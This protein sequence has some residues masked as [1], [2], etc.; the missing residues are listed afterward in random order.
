MTGPTSGLTDDQLRRGLHH[1]GL[2]HR[3]APPG[4]RA[5]PMA[6]APTPSRIPFRRGSTGTF[7]IGVEA[8]LTATLN[9]GTVLQQTINYGA[10][11]QVIYFSVDG[12]SGDAAAHRGGHGEL[13]QLPRLPGGPRRSAQQRD[14]LRDMPQPG[15]YRLH[16]AAH[17]PPIPS[18]KPRPTRRSTS[19]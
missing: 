15:E 7:M 19:P 9:P 8:R 5:A 18:K 4:R 6:P 1:P 16:H 14:V 10:T 2:C 11:N 17:R 13:Q 12:S 3:D